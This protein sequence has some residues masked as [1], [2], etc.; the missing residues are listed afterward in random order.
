MNIPIREIDVSC[1]A[2]LF[3]EGK[4]D[5]TNFEEVLCT[6]RRAALKRTSFPILS[7]PIPKCLLNLEEA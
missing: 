1:Y 3:K 5:C 7:L 4:G 6:P 2:R